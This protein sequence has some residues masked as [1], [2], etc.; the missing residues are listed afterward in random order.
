MCETGFVNKKGTI[1]I[2]QDNI[3]QVSRSEMG[4]A[5]TVAPQI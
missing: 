5:I 1:S 3:S 2:L 4:I